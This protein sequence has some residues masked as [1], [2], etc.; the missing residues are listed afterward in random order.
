MAY[1]PPCDVIRAS[2][3][4]GPDDVPL[5]LG[6]RAA[7]W[8]CRQARC[9]KRS[10]RNDTQLGDGRLFSGPEW[11]ETVGSVLGSHASSS[12]SATSTK[13]VAEAGRPTGEDRFREAHTGVR[14]KRR[15]GAAG[16]GARLLDG[17]VG[18]R[19]ARDGRRSS[20]TAG[21]SEAIVFRR[22]LRHLISAGALTSDDRAQGAGRR[23]SVAPRL[24]PPQK[25][26]AMD[27]WITD[28]PID[29]ATRV[30]EPHGEIDLATAPN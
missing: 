28:G 12:R 2:S 23:R 18:R 8:L 6:R 4:V 21:P 9:R 26:L 19:P 16:G 15:S 1:R 13:R 22:C 27:L 10:R 7:P 5:E 3:Q 17:R 25:G 14:T 30:V 20:D 24:P 11:A 29:A